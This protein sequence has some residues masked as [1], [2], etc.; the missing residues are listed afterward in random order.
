[1]NESLSFRNASTEFYRQC[2]KAMSSNLKLLS[3]IN[4][5]TKLSVDGWIREMEKAL[6]LEAI[7]KLINAIII[8]YHRDDEIFETVSKN[9]KLS[10]NKK[11]I[12]LEKESY[13]MAQNNNYGIIEID[14]MSD[15]KCR[16]DLKINLSGTSKS[17]TDVGIASIKTKKD[18]RDQDPIHYH[19]FIK[20]ND[21]GFIAIFKQT[22]SYEWED[23]EK[24]LQKDDTLSILLDLSSKQVRFLINGQ[25]QDIV[26]NDVKKE[27]AVKYRLHA[28]FE[29]INDSV[30]IISF[31]KE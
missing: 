1:M 25:D 27:K 18:F 17:A 11:C 15:I 12:T 21:L 9:V 20:E 4:K 23:T 29:A 24:T 8:L 3:K 5:K 28:S 14:S 26:F 16:W 30:E 22:S 31:C 6:Q 19:C 13:G 2:T 7:P 10:A